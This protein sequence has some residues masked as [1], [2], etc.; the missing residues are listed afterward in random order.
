MQ[1]S[2]QL[3]SN[4]DEGEPKEEKSQIIPSRRN[5]PWVHNMLCYLENIYGKDRH[6]IDQLKNIVK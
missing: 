6:P 4:R 5:S 3:Y 2:S 1:I